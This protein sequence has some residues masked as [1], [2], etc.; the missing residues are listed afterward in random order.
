MMSMTTLKARSVSRRAMLIVALVAACEAQPEPAEP[1]CVS[2]SDL[3]QPSVAHPRAELFQQALDEATSAGIP[4]AVM[5]IRDE[6]GVWEGASGYAD[7][8]LEVPMSAC[9]PTRIASV[10]KTFIATTALSLVDEGRLDLDQPISDYVDD[11]ELPPYADRI[12][13]RQLL[14]HTSGVYNFLDVAFVL[15]L[16]N[17]PTRTWTLEACYA[18]AL[19]KEPAL[20]PGERWSYSNTNYLLAAWVIEAVTGVPHEETMRE[21]I[22]EPLN[23]RGTRYSPD[24]FDVAGVARGY[25]DLFGDGVL[26]DSTETYANSCIGPDGGMVST[27]R[28]LLVFYDHLLGE[29]SLLSE[30][31][32]SAMLPIVETEDP[33]FPYYGLGLEQWEEGSALGIGHGGHEFGYRTWGYYFPAEDVTFVLWFNA[34]SLQPTDSN[35]SALLDEQRARLR[36]RVL[37]G[38]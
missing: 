33:S 30:E 36:D 31:S 17:Q 16:F 11:R 24:S 37:L 34:S 15:A 5:A 20:R 12:T 7:L 19:A 9:H 35:I 1:A 2:S 27:A 10:T 26:V 32:R 8:D 6:D 4:G 23:L 13:L 21:R 25:F 18:H 29:G 38:R 14:S 3:L 28:D 22:I